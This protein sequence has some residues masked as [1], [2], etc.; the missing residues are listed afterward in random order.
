M[1]IFR[2]HHFA[3]WIAISFLEI[4][5]QNSN[6][7]A[8]AKNKLNKSEDMPNWRGVGASQACYNAM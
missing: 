6:D 8:N 4:E 1:K 3:L 2:L 5:G 7:E